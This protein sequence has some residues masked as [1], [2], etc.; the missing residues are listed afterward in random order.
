MMKMY[1]RSLW[2]K[3]DS[4]VEIGVGEGREEGRESK[5]KESKKKTALPFSAV[6]KLTCVEQ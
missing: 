2:T 4:E 3:R 1:L 5:G 6:V